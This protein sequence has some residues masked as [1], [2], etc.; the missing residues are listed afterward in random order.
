MK[1]GRLSKILDKQ[2]VPLEIPRDYIGASN[3]GSECLRQI[4]YDYKQ[5]P[6]LP[7]DSRL[8]R[9]F[10]T[11]HVIESMI[12]DL[13]EEAGLKLCRLPFD[14]KEEEQP[15]FRGHVDAI[16]QNNAIIEIKTAKDSQFKLF[17][18]NGLYRWSPR[19]Y[20]QVQAYMG[21]SGIHKTYLLALNK[22]NSSIHDE[23]IEFDEIFY[24]T[25]KI[26]AQLIHQCDIEPPKIN[27]SPLFF[28]CKMCRYRRI[29]HE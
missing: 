28:M 22:D 27:Q 13:L 5:A 16:W 14:F 12:L 15:Y 4:W 11:G 6:G 29:C 19:Y 2:I 18:K 3:I 8:K 7:I 24:E 21:M 25:L 10:K 20:A 17:V 1:T 26:K 9:I 23:L